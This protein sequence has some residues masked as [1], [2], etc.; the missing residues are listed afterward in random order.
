MMTNYHKRMSMAAERRREEWRAKKEQLKRWLINNNAPQE[1]LDL[2][3]EVATT[4]M[5]SWY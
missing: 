3:D 2:L 4:P 5:Y 1:I